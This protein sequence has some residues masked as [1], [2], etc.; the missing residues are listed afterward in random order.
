MKVQNAP[1]FDIPILEN[2]VHS[3]LGKGFQEHFGRYGDAKY[4]FRS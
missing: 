4:V 2:M 1:Y 3:L